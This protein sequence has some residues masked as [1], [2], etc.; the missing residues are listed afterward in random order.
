[1][2][3]IQKIVTAILIILAIDF[4]G[5]IAWSLSGNRPVDNFYIGTIT[6]H[7]LRAVIK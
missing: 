7:T 5:F 3:T 2:N 4:A 6:T 1:M